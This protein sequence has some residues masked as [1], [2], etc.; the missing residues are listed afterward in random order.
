MSR[1]T[2]TVVCPASSGWISVLQLF[3]PEPPL[4]Q[5]LGRQFMLAERISDVIIICKNS[6]V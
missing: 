1:A 5:V 2:G 6:S 4:Q 3:R